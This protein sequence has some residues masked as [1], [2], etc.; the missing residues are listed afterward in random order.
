MPAATLSSPEPSRNTLSLPLTPSSSLNTPVSSNWHLSYDPASTVAEISRS[1]TASL[2]ARQAAQCFIDGSAMS[3]TQRNDVIRYIVDDV[4][5]LCSSPSRH[6]LNVI[7]EKLV[8]KCPKLQDEVD[9]TVVGCGYA[10]V[11]NQLENRVSY[12]KRPVSAYRKTC[13][14]KRRLNEST[15]TENAM[16]PVRDGYG[17]ADFLPATFPDGETEQSLVEKQQQLKQLHLNGQWTDTEVASLMATTYVMQRHDLVGVSPNS[18]SQIITEWPFLCHPKWLGQHLHRLLGF[19]VMKRMEDG[20][21]NKRDSLYN[22]FSWKSATM[23]RL[24]RILAASELERKPLIA[25][26]TLLMAYFGEADNILFV[27]AE[28]GEPI[29]FSC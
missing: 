17:C 13:G 20:I 26:I 19:D 1:H 29:N 7:A 23:K 10:S 12:L 24:G 9:G 11:R 15:H 14:V 18:I 22:F 6:N 5:K 16:K 27:S 28:V 21:G 2:S 3:A 25:L 8:R 4:L